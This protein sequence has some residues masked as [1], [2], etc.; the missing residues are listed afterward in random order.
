MK[1]QKKQTPLGELVRQRREELGMSVRTLAA[2]SGFSPSFISQ[3]ENGQASPSIASLQKITACLS[4]TIADLFRSGELPH[5]AVIRA[6]QR[7]QINSD[8]S[9]AHL[10]SLRTSGTAKLEPVLITL[11]AGGA[12]GKHPH[13]LPSEQFVFI[14]SGEVTLVL[15]DASEQLLQQGDAV[16]IAPHKPIYWINK[17]SESTQLLVVSNRT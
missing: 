6:D 1:D 5:T 10:E 13:A 7:P 4:S 15:D 16:T 14:L 3:V 17:S 2:G 11:R 8:W 9:K 12:S